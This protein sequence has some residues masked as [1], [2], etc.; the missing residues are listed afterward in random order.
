MSNTYNLSG[1]MLKKHYQMSTDNS[2]SNPCTKMY[3]AVLVLV[4]RDS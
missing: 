2:Y 3:I 1:V 4:Q